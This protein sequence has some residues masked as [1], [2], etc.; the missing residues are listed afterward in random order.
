MT[1]DHGMRPI[2]YQ[3]ADRA[4]RRKEGYTSEE[5]DSLVS[6]LRALGYLD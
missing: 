2:I 5:A 3:P 6:H 4:K 1:N